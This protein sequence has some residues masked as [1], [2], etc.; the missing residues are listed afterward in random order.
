MAR[1]KKPPDEDEL[2]E[3]VLALL[4]DRLWRHFDHLAGRPEVSAAGWHLA[5]RHLSPRPNA[6]RD[7]EWLRLHDDGGAVG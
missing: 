7:A 5:E 2:V 1:Y 4:S 6:S 3:A